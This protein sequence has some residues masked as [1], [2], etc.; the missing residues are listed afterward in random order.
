MPDVL[1]FGDSNTHGT[2]PMARMGTGAR[3][4]AER[5]WTAH[6]AA[7]L[8]GDWRLVAEGLP[9]RTTVFD[10]PVEGT[11]RNGLRTLPAL[12]HSHKPLDLVVILL[13]TN[14]QKNRF[15]LNAGDIAAGC[16]R[17]AREVRRQ[18]IGARVL[19]AAPPV[20]TGRGC[21]AETFAGSER[22]CAGLS[23]AIAAAAA[24][25]G[26]AVVDTAQ[27]VAPDPLD[28]VHYGPEAHAALGAVLA[29]AIREALA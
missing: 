4:P 7:A 6:A 9:G 28:G 1:L 17:L 2:P 29:P 15:G 19:I 20:V 13:G 14:D 11:W 12:L 24:A 26:A 3:L 16:A 21:L 27:A 5:R 23:A 25:E 18:E 10:D 8:G 22:R